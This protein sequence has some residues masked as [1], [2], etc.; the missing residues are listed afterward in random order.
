MSDSFAYL[1]VMISIVLGLAVA[2]L[3]GGIARIIN[4]RDQ[5]VM[6]WPSLLWAST[7]FLLVVQLWWADASLRTYTAWSF[8]AFLVLL[9]QPAALYLLCSLIL[10][11][12]DGEGT[13][14]MRVTFIR[15]RPWFL[16]TLLVLIALSFVKDF[17][18]YAHV[19]LNANFS[20][21]LIFAILVAVALRS[22][23]ELVQ[24]INAVVAAVLTVA[25]IA[26]LFSGL[27]N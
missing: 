16:G 20:A 2:H 14:D 27:P 1:A 18:L 21:L 24:K 22:R 15:N 26:I 6:Y 19:P 8:G 23:S 9:A 17:V 5:T 13:I 25:Y 7:L 11:S 12:P 3:L 4:N 10:P